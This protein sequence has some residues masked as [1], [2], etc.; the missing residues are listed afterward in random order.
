MLLQDKVIRIAF[1]GLLTLLVTENSLMAET[2]S[3]AV[4]VWSEDYKASLGRRH[5]FPVIKYQQLYH[6]AKKEGILKEEDIIEPEPLKD[7]DL[8][9]VHTRSYLWKLRLLALTPLGMLNGENPVS[10]GILKAVRIA[11]GGTY[12]ASLLALKHDV[13][14]NLAGGFHHAFANREEGFC[15]YNDVAIAIKKLQKEGRIEKAMIIDCD[16]HH[17]NGTAQIF[18]DDGSV[19]IFDIYQ[20]DNYPSP[21]IKVDYPVSLNSYEG[22]T[23]ERYLKELT[24]LPDLVDKFKPELIIYLAGADPYRGDLLGGF[25]LTKEGLKRRDKYII[26]LARENQLPICIVTAGGYAQDTDNTV[27]IH[28]NTVKVVKDAISK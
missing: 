5:I 9:L 27:Q 12:D 23:D 20:E 28:L 1:Y 2:N 26:G 15:Y 18:K 24:V 22:I 11:C 10:R 8:L 21:K 3:K 25:R 16:V 13:A 7:G 14:M 4:F 19:F 6:I 17:G